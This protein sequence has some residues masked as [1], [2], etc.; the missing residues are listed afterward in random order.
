MKLGKYSLVKFANFVYVC[1]THGK[2]YHFLWQFQ[3]KNFRHVI[4][5]IQNLQTLQDYISHIL[6]QF[7]AKLCNSTNFKTFFLTVVKDFVPV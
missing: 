1:I 7:A 3:L 5:N 6:Q 2:S 4:Q